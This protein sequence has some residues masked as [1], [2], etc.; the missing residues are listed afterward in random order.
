MATFIIFTALILL[1][2]VENYFTYRDEHSRD[3]LLR[4]YV[5]NLSLMVFGDTFMSLLSVGSLISVAAEYSGFGI[6]GGTSDAFR[7]IVALISF[8][9]V[10]YFWHRKRH[11]SPFLWKMHQTHHSDVSVNVTTA[12][13][14]HFFEIFL[15][16][17]VK[18]IFIVVV[19]VSADFVLAN[20]MI[21]VLCAM[22]HHTNITFRGEKWASCFMVTPYTHRAHHSTKPSEYHRNFGAIFSFWDRLFRTLVRVEPDEFGQKGIGEQSFLDIVLLARKER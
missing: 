15:T 1:M 20:E 22:F 17:I 13:R 12:F 14:L 16:T 9:L 6:L 19:G 21:A 8:D 3:T 5:T 4:S 11:R 10:L 7:F 18:S 2:T